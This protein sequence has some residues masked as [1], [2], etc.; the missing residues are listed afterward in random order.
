MAVVKAIVALLHKCMDPWTACVRP[1]RLLGLLG[2]PCLVGLV[3]F[4]PSSNGPACFPSQA[5]AASRPHRTPT[6]LPL[7]QAMCKAPGSWQLSWMRCCCSCMPMLL[8]LRDMGCHVHARTAVFASGDKKAAAAWPQMAKLA[9]WFAR[10]DSRADHMLC[11]LSPG[12][13]MYL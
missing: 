6:V 5:E 7:L 11:Q 12:R 3:G 4:V 9:A 2:L 10:A 13:H 8:Q 1:R